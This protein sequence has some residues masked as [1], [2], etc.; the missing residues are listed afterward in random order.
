MTKDNEIKHDY[1]SNMQQ[2]QPNFP[3]MLN[4]W[5]NLGDGDGDGLKLF[6]KTWVRNQNK[7]VLVEWLNSHRCMGKSWMIGWDDLF[8]KLRDHFDPPGHWLAVLEFFLHFPLSFPLFFFF[9]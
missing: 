6:S 3:L 9:N 5:I 2:R 8:D 1:P 7:S 4:E